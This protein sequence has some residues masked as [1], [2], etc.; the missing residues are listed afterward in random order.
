MAAARSRVPRP[1]LVDPGRPALDDD[2]PV[3]GE[4]GQQGLVGRGGRTVERDRRDDA[5]SSLGIDSIEGPAPGLDLAAGGSRGRIRALP[6]QED[7][8]RQKERHCQLHELGQ[9]SDG[10]RRH[11]RP[12]ATIGAAG[13][14]RLGPDRLGGHAVVEARR[15][16]DGREESDLLADRIDEQRPVGRQRRRQR[17]AG[18]PGAT[19]EI[20][21]PVDPPGAQDGQPGQAVNDMA[22]R[23]GGR[24]A[25]RRE[26]DRLIPDQQEPDVPVD[27]RPRLRGQDDV[28]RP[29][30][31]VEGV[32][33][34]GRERGTEIDARRERVP[35]TVQ[36]PLLSVVPVRA[37]RAPLPASSYVT[38]PAALGLPWLV[39]F[40]AGFPRAPRGPRYPRWV[41][42]GCRTLGGSPDRVNPVIHES[43]GGAQGCGQLGLD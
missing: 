2:E 4:I 27:R 21:E 39:R 43:T 26:V 18:I 10:A 9:G 40:A 36:A 28:E 25:N 17:D 7:A 42:C 22:D 34:R 20:D 5:D 23:D 1:R 32:V 35:R 14:Q 41:R 15:R 30:G 31:P 29:Q 11:G 33:I 37:V 24:V 16:D 3:V 12:L 38:P 8:A 6:G 19:P 13:R